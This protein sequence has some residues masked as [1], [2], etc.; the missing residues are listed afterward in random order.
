MQR[1]VSP[2][3]AIVAFVG[4]GNW[5]LQY[6]WHPS[7]AP[8]SIIHETFDN[9]ADCPRYAERLTTRL[10]AERMS[11]YAYTFEWHCL[12]QGMVF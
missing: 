1:L 3:I 9:A 6:E 4:L 10:V 12:P 7:T 11:D 8:T 5:S 2:V